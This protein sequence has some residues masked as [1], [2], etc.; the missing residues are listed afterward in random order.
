MPGAIVAALAITPVTG[1]TAAEAVL[2][3][4]SAKRMLLVLDNFEHVLPAA[5]LV[6]DLLGDATG[7]TI[8]ATSREP[9]ALHAEERFPVEPLALPEPGGL[10]A[11]AVAL[12][13]ERA[14]ARPAIAT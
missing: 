4:L 8:L 1:E 7:V 3:F 9:L 10:E 13:C 11:P 2:R 6:A 5:G 14:R 12:F